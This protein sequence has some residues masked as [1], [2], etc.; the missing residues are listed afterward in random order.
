MVTDLNRRTAL[1]VIAGTGLSA[2]IAGC[3]D[4]LGGETEVTHAT[5]SEGSFGY[6]AATLFSEALQAADSPLST[7]VEPTAGAYEAIRLLGQGDNA[8]FSLSSNGTLW[9][10]VNDSDIEGGFGE[11]PVEHKPMAIT[12]WAEAN[13]FLQTYEDR[14]IEEMSDITD[15]TISLGPPGTRDLWAAMLEM[16]G[17]DVDE[18]DT[19]TTEWP[20]TPAA[21]REGRA[22]VIP[23][24]MMS[25]MT[26]QP[27]AE[28][29]VAD[30]DIRI[31]P[32]GDE[33]LAELE[34]SYFPIV[35]L[36][37]SDVY[38]VDVG[39]DT[40]PA[41]TMQFATATTGLVSE[42]L[43]YEYASAILGNY[44]DVQQEHPG[45]SLLD[46]EWVADQFS[47][48]AWSEVPIHPG[49]A[50]YLEDEGLLPDGANVGEVDDDPVFTLE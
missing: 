36:D 15:Y 6:T 8:A 35:E 28:E 9:S 47:Q 42:D 45:L 50:R 46:P 3:A 25:R 33:Q 2:T 32:F 18:L 5:A 29:L 22:D 10:A 30:E 37:A 44:E 34:D 24:A 43:V 23:G 49:A 31:V 39:V 27:W 17:F 20:Q 21:L 4:E 11:N 12:P 26:V 48:D 16:A 41:P 1:S 14:G 19:I 7:R 13:N 40:I 38:D